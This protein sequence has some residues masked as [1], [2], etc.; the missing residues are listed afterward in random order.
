ML[1]CCVH[2][3]FSRRRKHEKN[4]HYRLVLVHGDRRISGDDCERK[5]WG[6]F[7]Y[8]VLSNIWCQETGIVC[9]PSR[10]SM[11]QKECDAVDAAWQNPPVRKGGGTGSQAVRGCHVRKGVW[12]YTI[13]Y[14]GIACY[15]LLSTV[16]MLCELGVNT[17]KERTFVPY[18]DPVHMLDKLLWF[19]WAWGF[20]WFSSSVMHLG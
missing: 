20:S 14:G 2:G 11:R 9:V 1:R 8:A 16:L 6:W 12:H 3:Q 18:T 7:S 4:T 19:V 10:I 17:S 15:Q 13:R 5:D